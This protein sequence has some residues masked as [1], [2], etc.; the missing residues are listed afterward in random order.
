MENMN[1]GRRSIGKYQTRRLAEVH[2]FHP[3]HI[4]GDM[5]YFLNRYNVKTKQKPPKTSNSTPLKHNV[6]NVSYLEPPVPI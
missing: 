3:E 1:L 2:I 4:T 5:N 6:M